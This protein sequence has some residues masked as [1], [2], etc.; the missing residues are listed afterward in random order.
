MKNVDSIFNLI[1]F[2]FETQRRQMALI[3]M[4]F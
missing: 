4:Q 1:N 3:F 2:K